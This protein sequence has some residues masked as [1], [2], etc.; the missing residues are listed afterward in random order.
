MSLA[1]GR[2]P[3]PDAI[4]HLDLDHA[5]AHRRITARGTDSETVDG[6]AAFNRG[7]RELPEYVG[8]LR[9]EASGTA[10][11]VAAELDRSL[12]GVAAQLGFHIAELG[13]PLAE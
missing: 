5:E 12:G 6:L 4:L 3:R 7:Y 8:F 11:E 13:F 2:L 1:A 9:I 10:V